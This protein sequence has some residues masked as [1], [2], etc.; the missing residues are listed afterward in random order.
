MIKRDSKGRFVKGATSPRKGVKL[1]EETK[2]KIRETN[3]KKGIRPPKTYG[4][5]PWNKGKSGY[6]CQKNRGV[7]KGYINYKGYKVYYR[8]GKEIS[9]HQE[10]YCK[11]W[12][13][14]KI[15]KGYVVHHID[16]NKQNNKIENL[17]LIS[18]GNHTKLHKTKK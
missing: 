9:E 3:I 15:P 6:H 8:N 13:I 11:H 18:R 12:H 2:K 10:I 17:K 7:S 5:I 4:R 16:E 14:K 1:S